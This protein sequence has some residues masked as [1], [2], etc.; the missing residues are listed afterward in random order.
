LELEDEGMEM[1]L[2]FAGIRLALVLL[3]EIT[4]LGVV[5]AASEVLMFFL[6]TRKSS[7]SDEIS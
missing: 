1:I 5:C 7:L 4:C 3:P 6:V 2:A